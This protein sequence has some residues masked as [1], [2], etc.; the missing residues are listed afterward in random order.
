MIENLQFLH[1]FGSHCGGIGP[2]L[3]ELLE[4]ECEENIQDCVGCGDDLLSL[5]SGENNDGVK[6]DLIKEDNLSRI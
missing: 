5:S 1:S 6:E 4:E 2:L 3:G